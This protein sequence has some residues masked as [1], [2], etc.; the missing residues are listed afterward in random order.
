MAECP[1]KSMQWV[2]QLLIEQCC[3]ENIKCLTITDNIS[4]LQIHHTLLTIPLGYS[5]SPM[6]VT[7]YSYRGS[8]YDST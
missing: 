7:S 6:T 4:V 8:K 3:L 5:P 1:R 2:G